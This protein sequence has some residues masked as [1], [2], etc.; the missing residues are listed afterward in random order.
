MA[1]NNFVYWSDELE[2]QAFDPHRRNGGPGI[3]QQKLPAGPDIW[4][5]FSNARGLPGG[6]LAAGIDPHIIAP[7]YTRMTQG[8]SDQG[9]EFYLCRLHQF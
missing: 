6:M 2:G 3:Y 1:T 8:S 9:K 4:N 7:E 5:F